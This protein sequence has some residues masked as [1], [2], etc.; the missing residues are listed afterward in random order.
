MHS[1]ASSSFP[2]QGLISGDGISISIT[3]KCSFVLRVAVGV[4][5][6]VGGGGAGSPETNSNE[7]K[8]FFKILNKK[9]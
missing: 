7:G 8:L 3:S 5:W 9:A 4:R 2:S 1:G 6:G